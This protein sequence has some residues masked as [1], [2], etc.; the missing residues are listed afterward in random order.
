M[1]SVLMIVGLVIAFGGGILFLFCGI[2]RKHLVGIGVPLL[3]ISSFVDL[4]DYPLG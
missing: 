3:F 4:L 2:Q 1:A